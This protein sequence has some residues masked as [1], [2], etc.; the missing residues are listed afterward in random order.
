MRHPHSRAG[1]GLRAALLEKC[2]LALVV[3]S[4]SGLAM[5][6]GG[7]EEPP[8]TPA[9]LQQTQAELGLKDRID[10]KL[11][12]RV[13]LS[14]THSV[15][16][17]QFADGAIHLRELGAAQDREQQV[18]LQALQGLS[19]LERFTRL[20]GPSAPIPASL[21][22]AVAL[23]ARKA[24][25]ELA[26]LAPP[27]PPLEQKPESGPAGR[28]VAPLIDWNA[29]AVWFQQNFCSAAG[30]N[31]V[32]CPTNVAWADAGSVYATFYESTCFAASESQSATYTVKYWNGS[33]WVTWS[34]STVAPRTWSRWSLSG[35]FYYT[36]HCESIASGGDSRV[37]FAHRFNWGTP[38]CIGT[39]SADLQSACCYVPI[40]DAVPADL[41]QDGVY[42]ACE[43]ALATKFAPIVYHSTDESNF[44]TNVDWFLPKTSIWFYDDNCTPDWKQ[45][46]QGAP[47]QASLLTWWASGGCGSSDTVYSNG[48]R[49]P[50]KQR[51]F[52]LADVADAYRVGSMNSQDWRTY[53]HAYRN[54][55]GGVTLQYWRFY[56][57]N[58]ALNN[59]GGD[60]EGEHVIL[61]GNLNAYRIALLGHTSVEEKAVGSFTWEGTHPRVFSE[62]GGHATHETGSGIVSQGCGYSPCVI[63]PNNRA[64]FVRQ[65]T[66]PSGRVSWPSG[67]LTSS[68]GLLNVG[69]KLHPLNGQVFIQYSGIWGSPGTLFGTSGYWGPAYNETGMSGNYLAAWCW[70]FVGSTVSSECYPAAVTR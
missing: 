48:T 28:V 31:S 65:E 6:C 58:D 16:F 10:G 43:S 30:V 33:A 11:V 41:D 21:K 4:F 34:S 66:W 26:P 47:T 61:D 1:A 32:W 7:V 60:W 13:S 46:L 50:D 39:P 37:D 3:T 56:A 64:T 27:A 68:G 62:G 40:R 67:S 45:Q 52:F 24:G 35:N 63:D 20:A 57:Y 53:V 42:D 5:A 29:D 44:P 59:H 9:E 18:D 69:E 54:T 14:S 25:S 2:A 23:A 8:A 22:E 15:E 70:G 17:W 12:A 38:V 55:V 51:T 36:A 49:S 19:P